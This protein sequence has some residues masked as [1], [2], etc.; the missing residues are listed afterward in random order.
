MR[1]LASENP[2]IRLADP[3]WYKFED[4]EN[5]G[6]SLK[7]S[8][9]PELLEEWT[10][11]AAG[12]LDCCLREFYNASDI[13]EKGDWTP[14]FLSL[15]TALEFLQTRKIL[16]VNSGIISL[17]DAMNSIKKYAESQGA[18]ELTA[19]LTVQSWLVESA[20]NIKLNSFLPLY[21]E[22]I[23]TAVEN[24][25]GKIFA[26]MSNVQAVLKNLRLEKIIPVAES[27]SA[28]GL[29]GD[30]KIVYHGSELD[31]KNASGVNYP[32]ESILTGAAAFE[33]LA[34]L[35]AAETLSADTAS[36]WLDFSYKNYSHGKILI[37][38]NDFGFRNSEAIADSLRERLSRYRRQILDSPPEST[39]YVSNG[40]TIDA[41][42]FLNLVQREE[43]F[44]QSVMDEFEVEEMRYLETHSTN[45]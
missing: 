31:I 32:S 6:W 33:F 41:E 23:L 28:A 26:A 1:L 25:A 14:E 5:N 20:L 44:F 13:L 27:T 29:F 42:E 22:E 17:Q 15:E 43:K 24:D 9:T 11:T 18:D 35:R 16:E 37:A 34:M 12:E 2:S 45:F 7:N 10:R 39:K 3:R 21:P 40:N 36:T 4:I 38:G 8:A 19:I 30:L